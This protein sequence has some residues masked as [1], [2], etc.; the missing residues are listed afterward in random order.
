MGHDPA[1]PSGK[2][3]ETEAQTES[4]SWS[5]VTQDA[6]VHCCPRLPCCPPPV[7]VRGALPS[8]TLD[9]REWIWGG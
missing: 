5:V 2:R 9:A 4:L 1:H 8:V 6:T 7:Q 3:W